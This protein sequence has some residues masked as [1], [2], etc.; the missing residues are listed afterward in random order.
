V[1]VRRAK[2]RLPFILSSLFALSLYSAGPCASFVRS[3]LTY[4]D[5]TLEQS[6]FDGEGPFPLTFHV[7]PRITTDLY[8]CAMRFSSDYTFV[9]RVESEQGSAYTRNPLPLLAWGFSGEATFYNPEFDVPVHINEGYTITFYLKPLDPYQELQTRISFDLDLR[10]TPTCSGS[11]VNYFEQFRDVVTFTHPSESCLELSITP[12]FHFWNH[13]EEGTI[14]YS[15]INHCDRVIGSSE[16]DGLGMIVYTGWYTL[17]Q[18]VEATNADHWEENAYCS[19][20]AY[21]DS[22]Q[23]EEEAWITL[24]VYSSRGGP[25]DQAGHTFPMIRWYENRS[26]Y[27]GLSGRQSRNTA[28]YVCNQD[29]GGPSSVKTMTLDFSAGENP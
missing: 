22:L 2:F 29:D 25:S 19:L 14:R 12:D 1:R 28:T 17:I 18:E 4:V 24:R 7:T 3:D 10:F 6:V 11:D 8:I 21:F 5:V 15:A 16:I 23:P 27:D 13:Q 9:T 20:T 26:L